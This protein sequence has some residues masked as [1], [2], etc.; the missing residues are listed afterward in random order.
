MV[1]TDPA[2]WL[3]HPFLGNVVDGYVWGEARSIRAQSR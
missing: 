1:P 3:I 2:D